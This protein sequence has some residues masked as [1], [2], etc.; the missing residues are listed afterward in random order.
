ML[1][2]PLSTRSSSASALQ[3]KLQSEREI[4]RINLE[5]MK[6]NEE[7]IAGDLQENPGSVWFQSR[8]VVV[9][10]DSRSADILGCIDREEV[11]RL[12]RAGGQRRGFDG[13]HSPCPSVIRPIRA[14]RQTQAAIVAADFHPIL[15]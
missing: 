13:G 10:T 15:E 6:K 3:E 2:Q 7:S 4:L 9:E 5:I 12:G 14:V 1:T 8:E 11:P